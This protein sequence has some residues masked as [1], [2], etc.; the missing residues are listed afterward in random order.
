MLAGAIACVLAGCS[1][2]PSNVAPVSGRVTLKGEPLS[3]SLVV[4][5]PDV[6]GCPSYARTGPDGDYTLTYTSGVD[7]AEIGQHTIRVTSGWP[8]NPDAK[9]PEKP[10]PERVPAKYNAQSELKR[11][12]KRGQNKI[13]L[14]L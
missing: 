14:E 10:V 2:R 11:E 13:D 12:V 3:N 7:G 6:P 4:F 5:T 9:P 8:G 1:N